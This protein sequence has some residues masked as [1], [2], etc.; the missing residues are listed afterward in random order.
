MSRFPP[1][2]DTIPSGVCGGGIVCCLFCVRALF[3]TKRKSFTLVLLEKKM[4]AN[5]A[6]LRFSDCV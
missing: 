2:S 3:R 6:T 5:D 4:V 1:S